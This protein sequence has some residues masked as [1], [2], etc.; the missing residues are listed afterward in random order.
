MD[1]DEDLAAANVQAVD[2]D[3]DMFADLPHS[4]AKYGEETQGNDQQLDRESNVHNLVMRHANK[5]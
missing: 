4:Q 2:P 1:V 5:N 3:A